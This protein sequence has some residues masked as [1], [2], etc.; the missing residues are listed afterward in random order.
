MRLANLSLLFVSSL[1]PLFGQTVAKHPFTA[2]DWSTLHN[3]Q[4]VA[5]AADGQ[6]ILYSVNYGAAKG[7][8]QHEWWTM[9]PD[10]TN[11][12]KL[13]LPADFH[14]EGF[15]RDGSALY[16]SFKVN[17]LMQFAVFAIKGI[18]T[19]ATPQ[20]VTLLPNGVEAAVA[21]PNGARYAI[22]A[23]PR[24]HDPQ[25][26]VHTVIE[27]GQTSLY[28]VNSDGTKGQWWCPDLKWIGGNAAS[29]AWSADASSVAVLSTTPNLGF[30]SI[31]S[32]I[33]VCTDSGARRVAEV[34]DS[35]QTIGWS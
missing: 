17:D 27:P 20:L 1:A 19:T 29:L 28:V 6:S 18:S 15:T 34:P 11:R 10:G 22:L 23:D 33:D 2:E 8:T 5:V 32:S 16:G 14:P 25:A 21:A 26:G 31:R 3:A 7:P 13:D 12:E 24:P 30:H 4:P 35:A 9:H